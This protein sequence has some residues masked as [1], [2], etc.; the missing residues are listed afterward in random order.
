MLNDFVVNLFGFSTAQGA[1]KITSD[2]SI[3]AASRVYNDQTAVDEGTQGLFVNAVSMDEARWQAFAARLRMVPGDL[4][5]E[6]TYTRLAD[7]LE[8]LGGRKNAMFYCAI[9]PAWYGKTA[10]GLNRAGL[11][12]EDEGY[13][14]I[15]I[16][17]PF[18]RDFESAHELNELVH[19]NFEETQVYRIDHY[20]GKET[21]QNILALRFANSLFE[22]L[23]NSQYV[24]SVQITMAESFGVQGRGR[25]YD[26]TGAVDPVDLEPLMGE[27]IVEPQEILGRVAADLVDLDFAR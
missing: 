10:T 22:P 3:I 20:L 16:E 11:T 6:G 27:V 14:R 8:E 25:F 2:R 26:E 12:R 19:A 23:W 7:T 4:D 5:D 9:P 21:V 13:R 18:G 24:D 17:K 15:V 1:V